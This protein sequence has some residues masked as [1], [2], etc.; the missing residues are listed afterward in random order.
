MVTNIYPNIS[1][2]SNKAKE[3]VDSHRWEGC[4]IWS[5][6]NLLYS[7]RTEQTWHRPQSWASLDRT[8]PLGPST[9]HAT[10]TDKTQG[11]LYTRDYNL[12]HSWYRAGTALRSQGYKLQQLQQLELAKGTN[13]SNYNSLSYKVIT[14]ANNKSVHYNSLCANSKTKA[15][16]I[17][18]P[19]LLYTWSS[20]ICIQYNIRGSSLE[21][22]HV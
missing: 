8:R 7:H 3:R 15:E 1:K 6:H 14:R 13:H 9:S 21:G 12:W 20:T 16:L 11:L 19:M 2:Y 18:C 10:E 17:Q 5:F 22:Q 4:L